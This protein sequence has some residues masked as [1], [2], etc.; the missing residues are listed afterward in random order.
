MKHILLL[1]VGVLAFAQA[2][3]PFDVIVRGGTVVDGTGAPRYL[4]DVAISGGAIAQIGSLAGARAT[5]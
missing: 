2:Q 1:A 3:P 4:A 5:T